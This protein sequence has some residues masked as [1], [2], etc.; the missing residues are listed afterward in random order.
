MNKPVCPIRMSSDA[1]LMEQ[2]RMTTREFQCELLS[3]NKYLDYLCTFDTPAIFAAFRNVY[4]QI[5][6]DVEYWRCLN[7]AFT[8]KEIHISD[9]KGW[10]LKLFE[11]K[12]GC[13]DAFMDSSEASLFRKL[14]NELTI[15][16]GYQRGRGRTGISW[17]LVKETAAWFARRWPG[18][19][20][21]MV[22]VGRC[23]KTD[24]L[25][26]TNGRNEQEIIINP[27]NVRA[28]RNLVAV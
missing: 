15:Y 21:P 27:A 25:G 28:M 14:P 22:V 11:A 19:G 13:R 7:L 4:A 3:Q 26:Y 1:Q 18:K 5:D 16:R 24:V 17:T 9:R 2:Y 20:E 10:W 8:A 6:D 23:N 12:R